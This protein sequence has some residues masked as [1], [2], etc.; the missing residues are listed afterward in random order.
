MHTL[1]WLVTGAVKLADSARGTVTVPTVSVPIVVEVD[2]TKLATTPHRTMV[3]T[4]FGVNETAVSWLPALS[5]PTK[6]VLL[7]AVPA[8]VDGLT[9]APG[10][11][12]YVTVIVGVVSVM[13]PAAEVP[14]AVYDVTVPHAEMGV[15]GAAV[16]IVEIVPPVN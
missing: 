15:S 6:Q 2:C 10:A 11:M 12:A 13:L 1:L 4:V 16:V 3:C 9:V 7:P 14:G 8:Y 5:E